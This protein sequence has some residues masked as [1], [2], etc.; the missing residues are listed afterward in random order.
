MHRHLLAPQNTQQFA[1]THTNQPRWWNEIYKGTLR[2]DRREAEV[3]VLRTLTKV[4]PCCFDL[5]IDSDLTPVVAHPRPPCSAARSVPACCCRLVSDRRSTCPP[6]KIQ[7]EDLAAFAR[8]VLSPGPARRKLLVM[9]RGKAE[10]GGD[11]ATGEAAAG[12]GTGGGVEARAAAAAALGEGERLSLI[13][14]AA[15][16][17]RRAELY[18]AA[19]PAEEEEG[20]GAAA[21]E[22]GG[23]AAAAADAPGGV[24]AAE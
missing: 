7:Q 6:P 2:F 12:A 24:V 14:D 18:A 9:V 4:R 10:R 23:G 15:A 21:V 1:A 20:E 13:A 22:G 17:K 16:F 5:H 19:A 8:R 11:G 3:A